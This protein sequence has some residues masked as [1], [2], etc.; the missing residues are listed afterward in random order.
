[1]D[2]KIVSALSI[3]DGVLYLKEHF[4]ANLDDQSEQVVEKYKAMVDQ[5]VLSSANIAAIAAE[6]QMKIK[7]LQNGFDELGHE[8]G[9]TMTSSQETIESETRT[10]ENTMQG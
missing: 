3:E 9:A 8:L 10:I 5:G 2:N 4:I 6:I 1:M 7:Q